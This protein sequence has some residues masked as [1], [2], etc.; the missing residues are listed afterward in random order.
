MYLNIASELTKS[1]ADQAQV[2]YWR[3]L[4]YEELGS[5]DDSIADVLQLMPDIMAGNLQKA[6]TALHTKEKS[7][8]Q[9]GD[10]S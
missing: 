2:F 7:A 3:A 5:I 4:A 6:M 1:E 8:E 9:P 10:G